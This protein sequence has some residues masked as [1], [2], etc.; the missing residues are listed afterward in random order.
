MNLSRKEIPQLPDGLKPHD[1]RYD[2]PDAIIKGPGA[3]KEAAPEKDLKEAEADLAKEDALDKAESE[4]EKARAEAEA[5]WKER[6]AE[7]EATQNQDIVGEV[8]DAA[9]EE[10]AKAETVAAKKASKVAKAFGDTLTFGK[11]LLI[12]TPAAVYDYI[13][14][15]AEDFTHDLSDAVLGTTA[16]DKMKGFWKNMFG[17]QNA[18]TRMKGV[19]IDAE[20]GR[21]EDVNEQHRGAREMLGMEV[22][23]FG[24]M[25]EA[26]SRI[27]GDIGTRLYELSPEKGLERSEL[28]RTM[29]ESA[30]AELQKALVSL[31]AEEKTLRSSGASEA[32]LKE[33][34]ERLQDKKD[35]AHAD[36][37]DGLKKSK[38]ISPERGAGYALLSGLKDA[39]SYLAMDHLLEEMGGSLVRGLAEARRK[40]AELRNPN[41]PYSKDMIVAWGPQERAM[42]TMERLGDW[43]SGRAEVAREARLE[44]AEAVEAEA[45]TAAQKEANIYQDAMSGRIE[46]LTQKTK[47]TKEDQG[48]I[49]YLSSKLALARQGLAGAGELAATIKRAEAFTKRVEAKNDD[50][51]LLMGYLAG[52]AINTIRGIDMMKGRDG[53]KIIEA[54]Q[55]DPSPS[56]LRTAE[57]VVYMYLDRELKAAS[58]SLLTN[59]QKAK[60][61]EAHEV[62]KDSV[63]RATE[64]YKNNLAK[65][66]KELTK[67]LQTA[68]KEMKKATIE[69]EQ[70]HDEEAQAAA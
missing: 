14:T 12:D 45:K 2:A 21:M 11:N 56:N 67:G 34:L 41:A 51:K 27:P 43:I 36:Y 55:K 62:L 33:A 26:V 50:E 4:T 40:N 32:D 7:Y 3:A 42:S 63:S 29:E 48:E 6:V 52:R 5:G 25:W 13:K 15:G 49:A 23:T 68:D 37:S 28:A 31:E 64:A 9:R 16:T 24:A 1:S 10:A 66:T 19:H 60:L 20:T 39:A 44:H 18:E 22:T 59:E 70:A 46:A 54:L 47:L 35:V 38:E 8:V 30:W 17:K 61:Q 69:A 57:A 53:Q 65:I 58:D